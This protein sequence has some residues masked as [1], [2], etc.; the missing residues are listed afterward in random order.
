MSASGTAAG[1]AAGAG[2]GPD[3]AA[4]SRGEPRRLAVLDS[5]RGIAAMVVVVHHCLLTQ[6]AFSDFFF[7]TWRTGYDGTV[8]YLLFHTPA[9]LVWDGY[10]A[11]TLFYVL[12]GLVL[13]LPWAE[14]RA[15]SW[16]AFWIKRV[17]RIYLPYCA[18]VGGAA[19]LAV[20]LV[21]V[22]GIDP[23]VAGGSAWLNAMGWSNPVT[24]AMLVD[25]ALMIGHYNTLNGVIHSLIWEMRVSLLFPL[26]AWP[27]VRW[28]VGGALGLVACLAAFIMATG[29]AFAPPGVGVALLPFGPGLSGP[30]KLAIELQWTAYYACFFVLGAT[31][32]WYL[33]SIR[34]WLSH[35]PPPARW[36]M[37]LAGLLMFQAHWSRVHPLQE[38]MVALGSALVI[39]AAL[40]PGAI[41]R[42]LLAAP[43]RF[44][45]RIS[46]SVYLVH[47]PM[48]LAAVLLLHGRVPMAVL[49]VCAPPAAVAL[50]W[51]FHVGI[52]DPCARLGQRL[53]SRG[54]VR[55]PMPVPLAAAGG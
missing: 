28:R 36:A 7:S 54:R 55:R 44:L 37:L 18:A 30:G 3:V 11:V 48:L 13:M 49:L 40:S 4:I 47:V 24:P 15:P 23:H 8:E 35:L 39:V 6:P 22:A 41:E 29:W 25:H 50:G 1:T 45:G 26:L 17:C 10:E 5:V 53:A 14:G 52:A 16:L 12:S 9:R 21:R 51:L 33:G 20:L 2:T 32:A 27:L 38:T 31:L 43:L 46:Y 19:A 34:R 42:A